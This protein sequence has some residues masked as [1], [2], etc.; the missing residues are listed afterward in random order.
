MPYFFTKQRLPRRKRSRRAVRK[1]G[2]SGSS[3]SKKKSLVTYTVLKKADSQPNKNK[4][5]AFFKLPKATKIERIST[6]PLP[7]LESFANMW[8]SMVDDRFRQA[9]K[10]CHTTAGV[11]IPTYKK[12]VSYNNTKGKKNYGDFV[13]MVEGPANN[14]NGHIREPF[15]SFPYNVC[16]IMM[17]TDYMKMY[18][19]VYYTFWSH[20]L[21]R[22][23]ECTYETSM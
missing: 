18:V 21:K 22:V 12:Y 20:F 8:K 17:G 6:M 4:V 15:V 7:M 19:P 16:K 14:G 1:G 3:G 5:D 13:T 2:S 10:T 11:K 9:I 23:N